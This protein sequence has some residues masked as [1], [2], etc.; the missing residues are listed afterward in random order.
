MPP[1]LR[2][3][4]DGPRTTGRVAAGRSIHRHLQLTACDKILLADGGRFYL[5]RRRAEGWEPQPSGYL[6][7]LKIRENHLL[8]SG[9]NAIDTIIALTPLGIGS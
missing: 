6:N 1:C 4:G 7:V 9:T 5:Y 3:Q 8:P 2:S